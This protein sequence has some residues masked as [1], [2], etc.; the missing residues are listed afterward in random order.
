MLRNNQLQKQIKDKNIQQPDQT[1]VE[2]KCS[3]SIQDQ[4]MITAKGLSNSLHSL[5]GKALA[6]IGMHI[7][8]VCLGP[9]TNGNLT[10]CTAKI[11]LDS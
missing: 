2:A 9:E 1:Q 8:K 4:L 10:Q 11:C 5:V 3:E 7:S 6:I